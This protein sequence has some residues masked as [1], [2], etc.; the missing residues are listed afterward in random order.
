MAPTGDD[1][2]A[3]YMVELAFIAVARASAMAVLFSP[4]DTVCST[5]TPATVTA[6]MAPTPKTPPTVTV[7]TLATALAVLSQT[8]GSICTTARCSSRLSRSTIKKSFISLVLTRRVLIAASFPVKTASTVGTVITTGSFTAT[9]LSVLL[10]YEAKSGLAAVPVPFT[11][12][13]STPPTTMI[14]S[15]RVLGS[16]S[17]RSKSNDRGVSSALLNGAG[18]L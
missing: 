11:T 17:N 16:W 4:A 13:E 7:S 9:T 3:A 14:I 10:V 5:V 15:V 1:V 8:V 12:G 18:V 2:T 6:A